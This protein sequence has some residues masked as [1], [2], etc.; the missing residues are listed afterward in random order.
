MID[1]VTIDRIVETASIV[2][3]VSDFVKLRKAGSNFTGLCP[4]HNEKTP[5][6]M[7]SPAR[8][9]FKCFGCGKGG[10]SVHFIMEHEHLSYYESLKLLA[11]KYHIEFQE[12]ELTPED[13]KQK[14]ET[15]SLLI[16]SAFAQKYFTD[17][18]HTQPEGKAVGLS[19][20]KERGFRDDIIQ[21]FQ[22]GYSPSQRDAFSTEA[23]RKGYKMEYLLK[24]GLCIAGN[25]NRYFDRFSDRVMFPIHNLMGRVIGFGGRILKT[26]EKTAKYLNSPESEIYHK[27]KILYGL[28]HAKRSIIQLDKCFLVEGYTDVL[29]M[30]Q[31]GIENVVASSGTSL[32]VEQIRLIKR[33][34]SNV[35]ILYDGDP[36]GIKAS[37]RGIDLILEEGLNVKVLLLPDND[38][39]D[40]YSRKHTAS[41]MLKYIELNEKDF[42]SFKAAL[43]LNESKGDPVKKASFLND[44]V[45]SIAVIPDTISR[46]VYIKECSRITE[47]DEAVLYSEVSKLRN[48]LYNDQIKREKL[49]AEREISQTAPSTLEK[50]PE[51]KFSFE[52]EIIRLLFNYGERVA[53]MLQEDEH[54][55]PRDYRI[56]E[57]VVN[58]F[59]IDLMIFEHPVYRKVFEEYKNFLKEGQIP[60]E[61]YFIHHTDSE[62]QQLAVDLLSRNYD[63]SRIWTKADTYVSTEEDVLDQV[64]FKAVN[65]FKNQKIMDALE[66]ANHDLKKIKPGE[67]PEKV[68]GLMHQIMFLTNYKK[69]LFK[70]LGDRIIQ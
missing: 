19:Y 56:A 35:T 15:E 17:Y 14:N 6:F 49:E 39:P 23:L 10:N 54:I 41:E 18:L 63:L 29:S 7:V 53:F 32:T 24:S 42:I 61:R 5:S 31:A 8:G 38:D 55:P 2:E 34:T 26:N 36:A 43:L 64:L 27:S 11:K 16:V 40:S 37:I 28:F 22:L 4:F 46:R 9:I 69:R 44:M 52:R 51:E 62:I 68:S 60:E 45:K 1:Q 12:K 57:F 3:V 30:H 33:F 58:E 67:D 13:I 65:S 25:E 20:F 66:K 21:K 59:S 50:V 48:R 47:F 70:T